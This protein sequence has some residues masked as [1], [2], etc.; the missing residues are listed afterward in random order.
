M[1]A[2]TSYAGRPGAPSWPLLVVMAAVLLGGLAAF[3]LSPKLGLAALAL[4]VA[5]LLVLAPQY[6]VLAL[7]AALPFDAVAALSDEGAFTLTRLL[8]LA[9]LGGW[10]VHAIAEGRAVRLATG[11]RLLAAYVLFA[12][13]SVGWAADPDVTIQSLRTLLQLFLLYVMVANVLRTP[14]DVSRALDVLLVSTG[15]L[16]LLVLLQ[17]P[18]AG[19]RATFTFGAETVN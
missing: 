18:V 6:A 7:V 12:V 17:L 2:S 3:V 10:L 14:A 1:T 9:V 11:G 19:G 4:P 8:G 15:V 5:P 16:A 13:V